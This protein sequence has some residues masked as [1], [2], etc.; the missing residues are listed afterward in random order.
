MM[1][2]IVIVRLPCHRGPVTD[3]GASCGDREA[4]LSPRPCY[5]YWCFYT[6]TCLAQEEPCGTR[7]KYVSDEYNILFSQL[8]GD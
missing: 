3:T 5:R 1:A 7:L 6:Y 2:L 8:S 4:A